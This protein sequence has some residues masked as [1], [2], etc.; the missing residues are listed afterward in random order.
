MTFADWEETLSWRVFRVMAEFVDGFEF[1]S[2]LRR[3]VTIFGSARLNEHSPY[4]IKARELGRMLA[5][6]NFTV[7]T[8]G[9]PGIMEAANRGAVEGQGLSVGLNIELPLE[10][11]F[12]P[13][14]KQGM[15]F[16]FFFSR[17]FMLDYSALAYVYFP[18]GFGTLDELFTV[19]T[20]IQT[21]KADRR[22]PVILVGADYWQPML[23]WIQAY[24]VKALST[25]G[26]E[27]LDLIHVTDDLSDALHII[28]EACDRLEADED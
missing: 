25:L 19:L 8:G 26:A 13:Y 10:Q 18:G 11:Q 24:H 27:D 14:V 16:H 21:G 3:T 22:I 28:R 20:L 6:E 9:G 2:R 4:Y 17:K 1:L 15:G 7:V 23:D 5:A 12:N